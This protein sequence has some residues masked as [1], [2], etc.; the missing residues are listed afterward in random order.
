MLHDQKLVRLERHKVQRAEIPRSAPQPGLLVNSKHLAQR[1]VV[2]NQLLVLLVGIA[3]PIPASAA[4]LTSPIVVVV[5]L[6]RIIQLGCLLVVPIEGDI[7]G[8]AKVS[9]VANCGTLADRVVRA[10]VSRLKRRLATHFIV[11]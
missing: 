4:A 9:C 6:A 11:V 5:V 2:Q 1:T 3:R 8:V 7:L 10:N